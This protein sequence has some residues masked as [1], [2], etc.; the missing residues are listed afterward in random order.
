M[1]C[2]PLRKV[3]NAASEV[4]IPARFDGPRPRFG[5]VRLSA[6]GARWSP[7]DPP[8]RR[9]YVPARPSD[10]DSLIAGQEL[11]IARSSAWLAAD[12]CPGFALFALGKVTAGASGNE[13]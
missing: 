4:R 12:G 9:R 7:V 3:E 2:L 8:P 10:R 6:G 11:N 1:T 5:R 13:R